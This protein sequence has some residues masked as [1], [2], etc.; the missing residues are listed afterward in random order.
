MYLQ[1]TFCIFFM[2]VRL[3]CLLEIHPPVVYVSPVV[4]DRVSFQAIRRPASDAGPQWG[5]RGSRP[6]RKLAM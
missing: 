6:E 4:Y 3:Q 2:R 5:A 1:D